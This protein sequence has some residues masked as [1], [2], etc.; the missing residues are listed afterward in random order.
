MV[1]CVHHGSSSKER[2]SGVVT[3]HSSKVSG[4]GRLEL[5][6]NENRLVLLNK[7]I[8]QTKKKQK[9]NLIVENRLGLQGI[10]ILLHPSMLHARN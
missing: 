9:M 8:L 10:L 3:R 7:F 2:R 4:G 5:T 1:H 6:L